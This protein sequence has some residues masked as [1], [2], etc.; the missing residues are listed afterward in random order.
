MSKTT[1]NDLFSCQNICWMIGVVLGFAAFVLAYSGFGWGALISM[2]V[3]LVVFGVA[4][5]LLGKQ[6]CSDVQEESAAPQAPVAETPKAASASDVK[7]EPAPKPAEAPKADPVVKPTLDEDDAKVAAST[8]DVKVD[9][10][11]AVSEPASEA[12]DEKKPRTMKAPRKAGADDLKKLKGV[13]PKLEQTLNELGFFHYDQIAK[14]TSGEIAWVDARL[15]FKG[16]IERDGWIE[17]AKIL[18]EGGET[19]FS[20]RGKA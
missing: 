4:G 13:G 3:G 17:Q 6:V 8:V 7:A 20:K 15:R 18:A 10:K 12:S 11:P 5:S 1:Q 16:R 9:S 19:E 14:W 2:V